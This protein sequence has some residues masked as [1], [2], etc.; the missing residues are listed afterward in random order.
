VSEW[1]A[2]RQAWAEKKSTVLKVGKPEEILFVNFQ[3][4]RAGKLISAELRGFPMT[5]SS[6]DRDPLGVLA[7]EFVTRFRAGERPSLT[8]YAHR[9]PGREDEVRDLFPALV[10]MEQLKPVTADQ[11]GSFA[12]AV[13]PTDPQRVGEF[14]ILR[15]VGF[16]GMGVVYEAVQESLGRHVALKLLP[17][18]AMAD[19]KRL[20]RF[21]REAKAA[22]R[23]HHTN[24]VPVFGTGVADGRYFYAMQY[25]AGHPLDAVVDEVRRLKDRS[26]PTPRTNAVS[27]VAVALVTGTFAHGGDPATVTHTEYP[28][29]AGVSATGTPYP[30]ED[31]PGPASATTFSGSLSDGGRSYWATVARVGAQV[32][33][34]L[35]YAHGQGILHRDVKPANLLLDLHGTVWVTDFGLAKATD[36]DDLTHA[37]DV[38][39]TLRYMAPERFEGQGDHRADVYALGL[40]LYELL[41][42][43]PAFG[44]EN[45]AKLVKDVTAAAPTPPRQINPAIPRDLETVVLK[46]IQRDPALRYQNAANLA[47]DLRRYVE[48][49]PIFARR[50]S[51]A[52]Q[53]WRWCRRNPA[54]ASLV[55]TVLLVSLAGASV[56]A[57]IA[58]Q[59][60]ETAATLGKT[61]DE[62]N[63][64]AADL[65][66]SLV[67]VRRREQEAVERQKDLERKQ[68]LIRHTLYAGWI[69]Q[70]QA[71]LAAGRPQRA[72]EYLRDAVPKPGEPDLRHWEWNYL[73]NQLQPTRTLDLA[74]GEA[75][76]EVGTVP[77]FRRNVFCDDGS[78]A[79]L[80][81]RDTDGSYCRVIDTATG[82]AIGRVPRTGSIWGKKNK[83][84]LMEF[85]VSSDG[86]YV[87]TGEYRPVGNW[88]DE[89]PVE[90]RFR[91]VPNSWVMT[92][93]DTGTE[94]P[95]PPELREKFQYQAQI[96]V[97][98]KGA[99]VT[100]L[101]V[102]PSD[103]F[104]GEWTGPVRVRCDRWD[105]AG[106]AVTPLGVFPV[107]KNYG[108]PV[109]DLKGDIVYWLPTFPEI[110]FLTNRPLET[111][112]WFESWDVTGSEPRRI[113]KP[114]ALTQVKGPSAGG[115]AYRSRLEVSLS[116]NGSKLAY[117]T[118]ANEVLIHRVADG[119]VLDRIPMTAATPLNAARAGGFL[120][121]IAF[122]S[123]L[124]INDDGTRVLL[125]HPSAI[126]VAEKSDRG[127]RQWQIP[128]ANWGT[129]G[130]PGLYAD[131][132]TLRAF[133]AWRRTLRE[134]DVS[135]DP[136]Q[137]RPNQ[138]LNPNLATVVRR[139]GKTY[140]R[141]TTAGGVSI[142]WEVDQVPTGPLPS[143]QSPP[144]GSAVSRYQSGPV[145]V[146]DAAGTVR[147][148]ITD[149]PENVTLQVVNLDGGHVIVRYS[150]SGGT[151][152]TA[153]ASRPE[154]RRYDLIPELGLAE[155]RH[156][157]LTVRQDYLVEDPNTPLISGFGVG[158]RGPAV[159]LPTSP[160][161]FIRSGDTGAPR[162]R[163]EVPGRLVR[164]DGFDPSGRTYLI[165][166]VDQASQPREI[167]PVNS[168]RQVASVTGGLVLSAASPLTFPRPSDL[169]VHWP[170]RIHLRDADSHRDIWATDVGADSF[171]GV[172]AVPQFSPDGRHV[173]F[174]YDAFVGESGR[175]GRESRRG[176]SDRLW[177]SRADGTLEYDRPV[178]E[179]RPVSAGYFSPNRVSGSVTC[180]PDGRQ[181][182]LPTTG[183]VQIWDLESGH[184]LHHLT[185]HTGYDRANIDVIYTPDSR[186]LFTIDATLRGGGFIIAGR[187]GSKPQVHVW[188]PSDGRELLT[189]DQ[190][191]TPGNIPVRAQFSDG[192]LYLQSGTGRRTYDGQSE[193]K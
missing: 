101:F 107:G 108:R 9:L 77:F 175:T 63:K 58:R 133:D 15:R 34:A 180:S 185:G 66:A 109:L 105:R 178:E 23:L 92:E 91:S 70:A 86:Q 87:L 1:L 8:E 41:T 187:G 72:E 120:G 174:R 61:L 183:E 160:L 7:E 117:L 172:M 176:T 31:A 44:A 24:I 136:N 73:H 48:D 5:D 177:V 64:V 22:A 89:T 190:G 124:R 85:V 81:D 28:D 13:E 4:L 71:S 173:L 96:A 102:P 170:V 157:A 123:F 168:L 158:G 149:L 27:E 104:T 143:G 78:R 21:K 99:W 113:G 2:G 155:R 145:V 144:E 14:R 68:D 112:P 179:G 169:N 67:V 43:R 11:T 94:I 161:L 52:E 42:L 6:A 153:T 139:E 166:S 138:G 20:E 121:D 90:S 186:R 152:P 62:K 69:N 59:Q 57:V 156:T 130:P 154:W 126:G 29:Q 53:A 146:R 131:N 182:A 111:T 83:P 122:N 54:V 184:C 162:F 142:E 103:R 159:G 46:A 100:V 116:P 60:H 165:E 76:P 114:F 181:V 32:A 140:L 147:G 119:E 65:D 3:R 50:A 39:G 191:D 110:P 137:Y 30:I 106:G 19:P 132:K 55:A 25:I 134:W 97:G 45:R 151:G 40:T 189:L 88:T 188:D 49:R 74:G 148:R 192:R 115:Q 127:I 51:K 18:E 16:G 36:S 128:V 26:G 10:E 33:D 167:P 82:K 17:A 80:W 125:F 79:F 38:I 135:S 118:D 150:A 98:P 95:L 193:N 141:K 37:G 47:D 129:D 12:P 93:V 164:F 171:A 163:V 35:A 84:G 75:I 56:A